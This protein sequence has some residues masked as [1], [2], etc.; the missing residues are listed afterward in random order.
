MDESVMNLASAGNFLKCPNQECN[1]VFERIEESSSTD[2]LPAVVGDVLGHHLGPF[3][4]L[5]MGCFPLHRVD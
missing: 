3:S 2:I 5:P 1:T 4:P